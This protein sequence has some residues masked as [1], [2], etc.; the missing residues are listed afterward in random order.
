M[1][2]GLGLLLLLGRLLLAP[3]AGAT[4][5]EGTWTVQLEGVTYPSAFRL[6]GEAQAGPGGMLQVNGT[7]PP[8]FQAS[9]HVAPSFFGYLFL[10]GL[11]KRP[12]VGTLTPS[13][14]PGGGFGGSL[15][16]PVQSSFVTRVQPSS[17]YRLAFG[18]H[19]LG[20]SLGMFSSYGTLITVTGWTT[21]NVTVTGVGGPD[22]KAKGS[23]A[24]TPGGLGSLL[25]VTPIRIDSPLLG[26]RV[27]G[28][29]TL[30]LNFVPE[31]G[32]LALTAFGALGLT[33]LGRRR[34]LERRS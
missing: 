8:Y 4:P 9:Y 33:V 27:G 34:A 5:F 17:P 14:G 29:G 20:Q 21:G 1:R 23:D 30:T 15:N 11:M 28:I 2:A 10:A 22:L 26:S 31:P 19:K 7:G 6:T 16:V 12:A 32:T 25:L 24:R 18:I 3:A 13:G